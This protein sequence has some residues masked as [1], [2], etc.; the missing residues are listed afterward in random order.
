MHLSVIAGAFIMLLRF[1]RL[2]RGAVFALGS[3]FTVFMMLLV[4]L[5][6]SVVRSGIMLIICLAADAA[7]K[8]DTPV[9]SLVTAGTAIVL[10][11]PE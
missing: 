2:K 7:G 3:T 8:V 11:S 6:A 10:F 1:F 4:G 5:P 9:I